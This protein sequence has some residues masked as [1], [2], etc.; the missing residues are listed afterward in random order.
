MV[1]VLKS[2]VQRSVLLRNWWSFVLRGVVA[3]IFGLAAFAKPDITLRA[4]ILVFAVYAVAEGLASV[5]GAL[6]AIRSEKRSLL[7]FLAG[8]VSIA[9]GLVAVFAPGLT[10]ITVLYV[11]AA[12]A[13]VTGII[14]FVTSIRIRRVVEGEWLLG[15]DGLLS[16]LFAI[17]IVASPRVG[18]L[19]MIYQIGFFALAFGAVF[20]AFGFRLKQWRQE[21]RRTESPFG[22]RE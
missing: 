2:D 7:L 22:K 5:V 4:L 9:A 1:E 17:L 8:V 15:F 11:I 3:I 16:I 20:V 14:A 19:I 18:A 12:W 21:P 6:R 10:E 13:F